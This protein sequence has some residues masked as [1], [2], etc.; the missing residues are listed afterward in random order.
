MLFSI[1]QQVSQ[2]Y[3]MASTPCKIEDFI[4]QSENYYAAYPRN[5]TFPLITKP[6]AEV[7]PLQLAYSKF[8]DSVTKI[9]NNYDS[10]TLVM[11]SAEQREV[12]ATDSIISAESLCLTATGDPIHYHEAARA[13]YDHVLTHMDGHDFNVEV[14]KR[15]KVQQHLLGG[16]GIYCVQRKTIVENNLEEHLLRAYSLFNEEFDK[17][18]LTAGLYNSVFHKGRVVLA[19]SVK[20][21]AT[22][23]CVSMKAKLE[24]ELPSIIFVIFIPVTGAEGAND[25]ATML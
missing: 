11:S 2:V 17:T 14:I 13:V 23:D 16:P 6:L 19:I 3:K 7:S 8:I 5:G 22:H 20:A 12:V 4:A 9:I 24:E 10:I 1:S 25:E 18:F 21:L 15:E